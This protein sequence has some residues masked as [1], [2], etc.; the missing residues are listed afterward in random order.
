MYVYFRHHYHPLSHE[1]LQLE[2]LATQGVEGVVILAATSANG[3]A[4][5]FE[6]PLAR[7]FLGER[8]LM[9]QNDAEAHLKAHIM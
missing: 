2:S 9:P 4:M 8:V 7:G 1:A 6:T 3:R 5:S